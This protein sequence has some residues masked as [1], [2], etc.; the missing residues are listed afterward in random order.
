MYNS[1]LNNFLIINLIYIKFLINI[2]K[3]I[4]AYFKNLIL[5]YFNYFIVYFYLIFVYNN[6][7]IML[8]KRYLK[9]FNYEFQKYDIF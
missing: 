3:S 9:T 8:R 4:F 6:V 1:V 2:D 7:I 5:I